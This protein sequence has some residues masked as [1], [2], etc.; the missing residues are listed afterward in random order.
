MTK[1]SEPTEQELAEMENLHKRLA[2][3]LEILE[4]NPEPDVLPTEV[5][6]LLIF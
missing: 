6:P 1:E 4:E 5:L 2:Q 3:A